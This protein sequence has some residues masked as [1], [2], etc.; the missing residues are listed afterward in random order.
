MAL[1]GNNLYVADTENHLI[2]R[3]DL[4][5]RA[6]KTI[7]GTGK[8]SHDYFKQGPSREI[9][10]NSPWDLATRWERLFTLPWPARIRSGS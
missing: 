7:A 9:G 5:G 2:R 4:K 3:V 10:L 6:V 8:Q 1:D